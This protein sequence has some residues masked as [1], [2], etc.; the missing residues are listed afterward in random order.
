LIAQYAAPHGGRG[1]AYRLDSLAALNPSEAPAGGGMYRFEM[2][3]FGAS[4]SVSSI[5]L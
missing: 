1:A 4:Q 2:E 5:F 3:L